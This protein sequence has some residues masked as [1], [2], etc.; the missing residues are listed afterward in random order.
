MLPGVRSKRERGG[1]ETDRQTET[2]TKRE[3]E[4]EGEGER[5]GREG[6][7]QTGRQLHRQ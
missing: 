5:V 6:E 2:E 4:R 7:T 1:G 3:G